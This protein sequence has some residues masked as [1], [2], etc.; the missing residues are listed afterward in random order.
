M[1]PKGKKRKIAEENRGFNSSWTESFAFIANAEGLPACLLC[2]EKLSNNKKSNVERHF[3]GKHATFA[4]KYPVGSERKSAIALLLEKLGF[5][6]NRSQMHLFSD[7][8]NKTEIIQKIKDMPLSAKT[9]KERAIKMA[10]NITNQQIKDINSAPAYS[11]ACDESCDV[12]DIEQAALLCRYVNSDGPQEEMIEL[13]PLKGQTHGEDIC[14]AVL[15][16]LND[17]GINT[18]H[19]ISVATDGAPSMRGSQKGF[20][21]L[22]Q[23]ALDRNLLAFHCILHQEALCAKTFPPECMEVMNLVIEMVNKIIAKALNH[24]QFRA[25]LDEV[26]SEYSDLLLHNKV[27][28][29]SRGE[30]LRR[31]VACLEHVKTFLKSKNLNYPQLED[32]EWL[33]KLHFMVDMTSHLNMLNKSLQGRGN[34]ALHMLEAVLSF[35]RKLTVFA[36][37]VQR[38]TLSHFPSLREFKEAY[39]D[40]TLNGDYLQGAIVDMQ[41]E[42]GSRFSEFRKEKMTLSFPVTSLEIDP[43]L[44]NTFPGVIQADLEME[45]A[46]I[47][48]KDLWVSKFKSLTAELEDVT[49]QKAQLAQSHEWSEIDSL[50]TI[51]KLVFQTWNALPDSYS[52]MKKYAFGVLSIFGST[53]LCEQIFSNMNYIKS[54][55]RTRLTDESLQSCVKIKVTSYMPDVEKLSSDVRKQNWVTVAYIKIMLD[56]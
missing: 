39:H 37:D 40:H 42:F 22:L 1:D 17:N 38:G 36:R 24:R 8:K 26:D 4:A 14:E 7:F 27:Q 48:D 50:P 56:V 49:R 55:Y 19:L 46:N 47:A 9:V 41:T 51:E 2:N 28:W 21:T 34:T 25:L 29:L 43:S 23:K 11:I 12:I 6:G 33:E 3:Q 15:K 10:G 30:V 20:V 13:I 54:K 35:E 53:Y 16:C 32:T 18:N 31:F 44:L 52:N 5:V 45:L